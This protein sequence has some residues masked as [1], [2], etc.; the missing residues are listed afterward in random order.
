MMFCFIVFYNNTQN[1][2]KTKQRMI[3]IITHFI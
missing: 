1:F 3:F 2:Y